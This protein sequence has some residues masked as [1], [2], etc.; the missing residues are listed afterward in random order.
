MLRAAGHEVD[1]KTGLT[2]EEL[3][4]D[5]AP[6]QVVVV[7][8]ATKITK[9]VIDAAPGLKAVIR[10]G[11]G[12][13]NIDE[14]A[15]AARGVTVLSTPEA[16]TVSVAEHALG[17]MFSVARRIAA[18]HELLRQGKW[19]KKALMG[20]ELSGKTLGLIGIGRIGAEVATRARALG[21]RVMAAR[22]DMG[23]SAPFGVELSGLDALLET[24]DFVSIHVPGG[25]ETK[26]LI[27]PAQFARMKKG[28]FLINCSRGGIVDE[29]ALAEALRSGRLA[30][31]AVDVFEEEPP[32]A[33]NPL[34][35]LDN[36]VLT[37]HLGAMT[38]EGQDRVG[39]AV[40]KKL[41][42][43]FAGGGPT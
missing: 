32:K 9:A 37:P 23:R 14:A 26:G 43:F 19:E 27:G 35:R 13:D 38:H 17:M 36:I 21:M 31:A 28:A 12:L 33:D 41:L 39:A 22:R 18:A 8:S 3:A 11:A 29:A 2:P 42:E 1:V 34:L 30:G 10:G 40:A 4:R 25:P 5:I 16:A 7:R 20:T 6:Y 24:A 15:C